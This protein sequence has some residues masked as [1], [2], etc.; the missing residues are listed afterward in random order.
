MADDK[1]IGD[2]SWHYRMVNRKSRMATAGKLL[3]GYRPPQFR[4]GIAEFVFASP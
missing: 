1:W 2:G 4:F 3:T